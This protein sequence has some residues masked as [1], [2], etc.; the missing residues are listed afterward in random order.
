MAELPRP[1]DYRA[2]TRTAASQRRLDAVRAGSLRRRRQVN[3][4]RRL[5][6]LVGLAILLAS[7]GGFGFDRYDYYASDLPDPNT[8]D[9]QSLAQPTSILD[10]NGREL[11][12]SHRPGEIRIVVGLDKIAPVLRN[13][14][15]DIE[16]KNFYAHQ[17]FDYQRLVGAAFN[18][19]TH[20]GATQG[21]STITQQLAK[22]KYLTNGGT[23]IAQRSL[24]RKAKEAL[25]AQ[26][27]E[28]RYTKDQILEAY[29]NE[30]FYGHESYGI[31]AAA[32]T[33]FGKHASE[34][35]LNEASLL[36]GIPQAPAIYDPLTTEGLA[37]ARQRQR[38]V[39]DAMVN[40]GHA[41]RDAAEVAMATPL[42]FTV[43]QDD[44][45]L[46]APHFVFYVLDYLRRNYGQDALNHGLK[47]T[48]TLDL[49]LQV[50]AEQIVRNDVAGFAS[51]GVNNGAMVAINPQTG[52]VI[53]Y[54]GSANYYDQSI[55]GN[56]DNVSAIGGNPTGRQPGSSFKPYVYATALANGWAPGSI[57][58]D[59][60]GKFGDYDAH[61]FD[62][63][64]MGSMTVRSA[65]VGSRNIP[66]LVLLGQ[67]GY[68]RVF[69]V[70]RS[71][72][73]TTPLK[74]VAG[75]AIGVS[76]VKMIEHAQAFGVFATGGLLHPVT[77]VLRVQDSAGKDLPLPTRPGSSTRV[78]TPQ[79]AY[80]MNDMLLGYAKKW[81]LNLIGPAAG[82]SGTTDNGVDLWYMGYTPDLVV[83]TWMARTGTCLNGSHG[84][85]ALGDNIFGVETASH[86]FRDYLPIYYNQRTIPEFKKPS[87]I[88]SGSLPC[89]PAPYPIYPAPAGDVLPS[90]CTPGDIHIDGVGY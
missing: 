15:V 23:T 9:P 4:S 50:Q 67:L 51:Q 24:D 53:S 41:T 36:A 5:V 13:A 82:K 73:I 17:G 64:S 78:L 27:I 77:P 26:E 28:A 7:L 83:G 22:Y 34:L 19:L 30:I 46:Y 21:G 71:M 80:E 89:H 47:V 29:L 88:V 1:L 38:E 84:L 63:R 54:V 45:V 52:E 2:R 35:D 12:L 39:L 81:G 18:D 56:V 14:A 37:A 31:E 48:T 3:H 66:P 60:Q 68:D 69:Q 33:Y 44:R 25:L 76:E 10:R 85:C 62:K 20:A 70:A 61:D 11:Y 72:G 75:T 87:G 42:Q 57:V 74:R 55:A 16:D 58:E 79:V 49:N 65:L 8:L 6:V 43:N 40:Q 86:M 32:Q 59:I 90:V